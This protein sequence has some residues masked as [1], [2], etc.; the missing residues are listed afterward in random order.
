MRERETRELI[1]IAI[2]YIKIQHAN[3]QCIEVEFPLARDICDLCDD[4][5][6]VYPSQAIMKVPLTK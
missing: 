6:C 1:V 5:F 3:I 2:G 4:H